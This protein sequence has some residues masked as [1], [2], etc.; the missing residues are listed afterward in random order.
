[1]R[2]SMRGREAEDGRRTLSG[3]G[4]VIESVPK[5][6]APVDGSVT[7]LAAVKQSA[8]YPVPAP[9]WHTRLVAVAVRR[10]LRL[11]WPPAVG[12]AAALHPVPSFSS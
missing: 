8:V 1:M 3:I 9:S 12:V 5:L 2:D 4:D 10:L 7:M 11:V 6:G